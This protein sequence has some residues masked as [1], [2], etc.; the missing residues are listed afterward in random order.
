MAE[1]IR[2]CIGCRQRATRAE[3]VRFANVEGRVVPDPRARACG[4]GAW[5]HEARGCWDAA[6]ARRAF[7]RAFRTPVTIPQE[8][9]DFTSTWPRSAYTS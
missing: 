2:T 6:V 8:T 1:P 9:L 7:Q 5:L 4:R 3:L